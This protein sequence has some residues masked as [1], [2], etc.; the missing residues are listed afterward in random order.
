MTTASEAVI[1]VQKNSEV[2]FGNY[3]AKVVIWGVGTVVEHGASEHLMQ[4][5]AD[6]VAA[7]IASPLQSELHRLDAGCSRHGSILEHKDDENC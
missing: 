3:F 5:I 4:Q 6:G 2:E 7:T 1:L